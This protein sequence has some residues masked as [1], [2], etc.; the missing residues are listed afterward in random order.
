MNFIQSKIRLNKF[1]LGYVM[2]SWFRLGKIK[3]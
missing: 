3:Q 1:R 2:L